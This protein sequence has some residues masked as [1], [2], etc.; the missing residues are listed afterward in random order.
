M[1]QEM[2]PEQAKALGERWMAADGFEWQPGIRDGE[3]GGIVV[4]AA[5]AP[6]V[7]E[8]QPCLLVWLQRQ[9]ED[10]VGYVQMR[11][12]AECWPDLRHPGTLGFAVAAMRAKLGVH[13]STTAIG[14]RGW[15]IEDEGGDLVSWCRQLEPLPF[16]A[17]AVIAAI[18][19]S[20]G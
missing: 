10:L 16:E 17:E 6:E 4:G 20:N 14:T 1:S 19:V 18:E 9:V 2:T 12:V 13:H 7:P 3:T 15:L 5:P 8:E 11:P